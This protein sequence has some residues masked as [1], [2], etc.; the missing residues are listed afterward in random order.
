MHYRS[1]LFL[2]LKQLS[3]A[4]DRYL[5]QASFTAS[6]VTGD[7]LITM[8]SFVCGATTTQIAAFTNANY[9]IAASSIG[10]QTGCDASQLGAYADQAKT[11]YGATSSWDSTTITT[12]GVVIAGLTSSEISALTTTQIQS[13]STTTIAAIPATNFAGFSDTQLAS[14][15][16]AQAN[17]V[18]STQQNALSPA[19]RASLV[20]AGASDLSTSSADSN[21]ATAFFLLPLLALLL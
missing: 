20:S 4:F 12:V 8:G 13:I 1:V 15:S 5:S 6:Q 21:R 9:Q 17:S 3:A 14:F 19:Q 11:A 18:T 2:Y 10:Q 16:T 7:G